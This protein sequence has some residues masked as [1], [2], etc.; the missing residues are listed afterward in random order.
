L[1]PPSHANG[2]PGQA[3]PPHVMAPA[4]PS[5]ETGLTVVLAKMRELLSAHARGEYARA[6]RAQKELLRM[7]WVVTPRATRAPKGGGR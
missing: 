5:G 4:G 3:S 2:R 1:N 7:G 6:S